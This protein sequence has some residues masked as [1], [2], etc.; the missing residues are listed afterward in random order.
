MLEL[1]VV[2]SITVILAALALSAAMSARKAALGVKCLGN[3]KTIHVAMSAFAVEYGHWPSQNRET[4]YN[5]VQYGG[6]PWFYVLLA[7]EYLPARREIQDGKDCLTC[8]ALICPANQA[9]KGGIFTSTSAPF[10]IEPNYGTSCYW[11]DHAGTPNL[12]PGW[13]DRVGFLEGIPNM[14]AILLVDK[15]N[16]WG[17]YPWVDANWKNS[18]CAIP[19]N[20]HGKGAHAL[21]ANGAV[22]LISPAS[23]PDLQEEKYWNP[24]WNPQ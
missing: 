11:G 3:M 2:I 14:H 7:Q 23:H 13:M 10:P 4:H 8:D 12:I 20:L 15:L 5:P 6:S 22:I 9:N 24:R 19:K 21:L 18:S 1:L 16:T 17:T